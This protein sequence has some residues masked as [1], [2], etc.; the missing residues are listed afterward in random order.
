MH[1]RIDVYRELTKR[2]DVLVGCS[3]V[4]DESDGLNVLECPEISFRS[5]RW[6]RGMVWKAFWF[7]PHVIWLFADVNYVSSFALI[8]LSRFYRARV[9][10]HGQGF[11]KPSR[12]SFLREKALRIWMLFCSRYVCYAEIC[13]QS[14]V[15]VGFQEDKLCVV[16]N[17]FESANRLAHEKKMDGSGVL[18]VGRLRQGSGLDKLVRMIHV[19]NSR[20]EA[21]IILHVVGDGPQRS[22]LEGTC[23]RRYVR[24]YGALVGYDAIAPIAT[25]CVCGIYPGKAGLSV[26]TYLQHGLPVICDEEV[27]SHMGPEP[28]FLSDNKDSFLFS[29]RRARLLEDVLGKY[30]EM[31]D[32]QKRQVSQYALETFKHLHKTPYSAEMADVIASVIHPS[33]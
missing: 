22:E 2:F 27:S 11:F 30:L 15:R 21:K 14:L 29:N 25:E 17:R 7:R 16:R 8:L 31:T 20:R 19:L 28:S 13:K 26:L 33:Q 23:D 18:F 5:F 32:A 10:L 9:V 24:F 4:L 12:S 3:S 1:Y 6:Q